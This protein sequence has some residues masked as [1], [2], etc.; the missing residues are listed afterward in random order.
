MVG[1]YDK[2][3]NHTDIYFGCIVF[4]SAICSVLSA[5]LI[6]LIYSMK[7]KLNGFLL[8]V[9]SMSCA[10]L[11]YD[12]TFV[13]EYAPQSDSKLGIFL[14]NF[15][16]PLGGIFVAVY[17]NALTYVVFHLI[18]FKKSIDVFKSFKWINLTAS[19]IFIVIEI[20]V[21]LGIYNPNYLYLLIIAHLYVY[22][23]FRLIS[24]GFNF[25]TCGLSYFY[26]LKMTTGNSIITIQDQAICTLVYRM[27]YYPIVQAASRIG[28]SYYQSTYAVSFNP[29]VVTRTQFIAQLFLA[30]VTPSASVGYFIIFIRMQPNAYQEFIK[31]ITCQ[32]L[33]V[34]NKSNDTENPTETMEDNS[35][36]D[37]IPRAPSIRGSEWNV[38]TLNFYSDEE[39]CQLIVSETQKD[40]NHPVSPITIEMTQ[41][42]PIYHNHERESYFF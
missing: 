8:L 39:L 18:K 16:Q 34:K 3:G 17:S 4:S 29:P 11:V 30:I 22:Y 14:A 1:F 12:V 25:L 26:V 41:P 21:L 10:Q 36:I 42:N 27:L 20:M 23:Y 31:L 13:P 35:Q 15:L 5:L 9:L 24:I 7:L 40:D 38:S 28:I 32:T 2:G 19:L 6:Y 33:F 37:S